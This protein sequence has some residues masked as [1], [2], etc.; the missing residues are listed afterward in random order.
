LGQ[1]EV[2]LLANC[3]HKEAQYMCDSCDRSLLLLRVYHL[4]AIFGEWLTRLWYH[5]DYVEDQNLHT[6]F[7]WVRMQKHTDRKLSEKE[8]KRGVNWRSNIRRKGTEC[9]NHGSELIIQI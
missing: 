6:D 7:K 3:R 2:H 9:H 4:E 8:M 5:L 1:T